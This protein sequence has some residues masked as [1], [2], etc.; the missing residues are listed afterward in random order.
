M[1][2]KSELNSDKNLGVSQ[3]NQE[4]FMLIEEDEEPRRAVEEIEKIGS[5]NTKS[6]WDFNFGRDDGFAKFE[7][8]ELVIKV[9]KENDL[10]SNTR[11]I[12]N[13][14]NGKDEHYLLV[15][16]P[17]SKKLLL[18]VEGVRIRFAIKLAI[19]M[20]KAQMK[21]YVKLIRNGS[22]FDTNYTIMLLD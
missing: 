17:E 22:G 8:N 12:R 15:E 3:S 16:T 13:K 21:K 5:K 20:N 6:L 4:P 9:P 14:F 18:K 19:T 1:V 11:L 10:E 7:N 2:N